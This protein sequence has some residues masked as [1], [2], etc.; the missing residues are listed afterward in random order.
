MLPVIL[1]VLDTSDPYTLTAFYMC[2]QSNINQD[3]CAMVYGSTIFY[4]SM[5]SD[6]L[7]M[8]IW[9]EFVDGNVDNEPVCCLDGNIGWLARGNALEVFSGTSGERL[10]AWCFGNILREPSTCITCV[11][12]YDCDSGCKMII[13]TSSETSRAGMLCLFCIKTSKVIRAIEV[14]CKVRQCN[15]AQNCKTFMRISS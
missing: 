4:I 14:P 3:T 6:I 11:C 13:A 12:T 9:H 7:Q 1:I 10:A 2:L 5:A 15:T 8:I